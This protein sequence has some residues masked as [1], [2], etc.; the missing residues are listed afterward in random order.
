MKKI[1]ISQEEKSRIMESH[2][3]YRNVLMGHLFDKSLLEEQAQNPRTPNEVLDLAVQKCTKLP[4][5]QRANFE[6][7]PALFY[8]PNE[9]S[10]DSVS[11]DVKWESG[12]NVYFLGDMTWVST[13]KDEKGDEI[14]RYVG[15][16]SCKDLNVEAANLEMLKK[17]YIS[18]FQWKEYSTLSDEDKAL[19]Q[20]NPA[21]YEVMYMATEPR[22]QLVR[23]KL[24]QQRGAVG[25][26]QTDKIN[27]YLN[28]QGL[29][30]VEWKYDKDLTI[31][32]REEWMSGRIVLGPPVFDEN[33]V[34]Y[35]NP[36]QRGAKGL[37]STTKQTREAQSLS[38]GDCAKNIREYYL[39]WKEGADI[40]FA[41][42]DALKKNVKKCM[43]L[44]HNYKTAG[45]GGGNVRKMISA[46]YGRPT[47]DT[48]VP[49]FDFYGG[50]DSAF[51]TKRSITDPNN[52]N[53]Y[54]FD[55][56]LAK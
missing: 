47:N 32:Q 56:N 51:T 54:S 27:S 8:K 49:T 44:G 13:Y 2:N 22:T 53:L 36:A 31:P 34:I 33:I 28:Q 16:W 21:A 48:Q 46:M 4:A 41:K 52:Q 40:S 10:T 55:F 19:L 50:P 43:R 6:G 15:R 24:K 38:E 30:G 37:A 7:K 17:Q 14:Q 12:D 20:K 25:G 11:G 42:L 3:T 1:A 26:D 18:S 29:T 35:M 45:V 39:S 23:N 5:K 9:R